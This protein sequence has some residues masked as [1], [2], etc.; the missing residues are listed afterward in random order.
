MRSLLLRFSK[1]RIRYRLLWQMASGRSAR[2]PA[3]R[4]VDEYFGIPARTTCGRLIRRS[5]LEVAVCPLPI[6]RQDEV[7]DTVDSME[8]QGDL[9]RLFTEEAVSFIRRNQDNPF[10]STF[11]MPSFTIRDMLAGIS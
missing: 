3:H 1:K 10:S 6:I 2:V 9:C 5:T 7:V 8:E 11:P 4:K